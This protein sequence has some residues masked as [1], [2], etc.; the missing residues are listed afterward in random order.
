VRVLVTGG[1]GFIG[2]HLVEAL[3]GQ[4]HKVIVMDDLSLGK[5]SN[6][7]SV[8]ERRDL[9]TLF[10]DVRDTE[11]VSDMV[12]R[13]ELVYHLAGWNRVKSQADLAEAVGVNVIAASSV[14]SAA[15][16]HSVRMVYAS[17]SD[18]YGKQTR[19]P[20][21]EESECRLGPT[22]DPEWAFASMKLM[23]ETAC[24]SCAEKELPVTILRLFDV[25]GPRDRSGLTDKLL[26][27]KASGQG[28][29]LLAR[30]LM[31]VSDVVDALMLAGQAP[32]A[33]GEII[34][35]GWNRPALES[36]VLP[37]SSNLWVADTSKA[38]RLLGFEPKVHL[39]EGLALTQS[40]V[41]EAG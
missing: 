14:L 28:D 27:L 26:Q 3:L 4:E 21:C 8:L 36:C 23:A 25:Y 7:A 41:G 16:R 10:W 17:C 24:L 33:V 31:Y 5:K 9:T 19:Q 29:G 39:D 40:Y 1:A 15:L 22:S 30:S 38:R 13:A 11:F 12:K 20:I 18:V 37:D 6:L 34:N 35:I 2:S 32:L